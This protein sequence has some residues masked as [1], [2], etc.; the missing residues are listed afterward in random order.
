[1][2]LGDIIDIYCDIE[3]YPTHSSRT[4][5]RKAILLG[6]NALEVF[7]SLLLD[8]RFPGCRVDD[9]RAWVIGPPDVHPILDGWTSLP[10]HLVYDRSVIVCVKQ[11]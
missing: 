2:E 1:M 4:Y 10:N 6:Y 8:A 7:L 9:C 5:T 11:R 3:G